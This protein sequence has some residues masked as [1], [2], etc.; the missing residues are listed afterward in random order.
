MFAYS[1]LRSHLRVLPSPLSMPA[2]RLNE[3]IVVCQILDGEA[4]LMSFDTG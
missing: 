2:Y 1:P 3:P 4:V